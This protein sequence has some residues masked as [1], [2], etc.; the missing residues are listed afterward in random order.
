MTLPLKNAQ[1]EPV[2]TA[3]ASALTS[4][5]A[6]DRPCASLTSFSESEAVCSRPAPPAVYWTRDPS[7]APCP[8]QVATQLRPNAPLKAPASRPDAPE[9]APSATRSAAAAEPNE[10]NLLPALDSGREKLLSS[11]ESEGVLKDRSWLARTLAIILTTLGRAVIAA[12]ADAFTLARRTHK[13]TP[14][15][16]L[17]RIIT[18]TS[19]CRYTI[20]E[21]YPSLPARCCVSP[22]RLSTPIPTSSAGSSHRRPLRPS[23]R[24]RSPSPPTP[25]ARSAASSLR[26]A[27]LAPPSS[28]PCC[29]YCWRLASHPSPL[30]LPRRTGLCLHLDVLVMKHAHR[31]R[32]C[33]HFASLWR[34]ALLVPRTFG[35]HPGGARPWVSV[36]VLKRRQRTLLGLQLWLERQALGLSAVGCTHGV[37]QQFRVAA[38]HHRSRRGS[39]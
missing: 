5:S 16:V 32:G 23:R 29:V 4:L 21:T 14:S 30:F 18:Q 31:C 39:T 20:A 12:V 37:H 11:T 27:S 13:A 3:G 19:S 22:K 26:L 35:A 33:S 36:D 6:Q 7:P 24:I 2:T 25:R 8:R 10:T 34:S 15:P 28:Q 17:A 38:M 1:T 9:I